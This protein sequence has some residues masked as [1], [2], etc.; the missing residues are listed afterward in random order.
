MRKNAIRLTESELITLVSR[1]VNEQT[2]VEEKEKELEEGFLGDKIGWVMDAAKNVAD[3]F[4]K[5]YIDTGKMP[6]KEIEDLAAKAEGA[7]PSEDEEEEVDVEVETIS[8]MKRIPSSNVLLNEGLIFEGKVR[9]KVMRLLNKAGILGGLGITLGGFA[10]FVSNIPGYVDST[11][12]TKVHEM[13]E[14]TFNCGFAC[15][16]LGFLAMVIGIAIAIFNAA[17]GHKRRPGSLGESRRR[18]RVIREAQMGNISWT[19]AKGEEHIFKTV[20]D[21]LRAEKKL[22]LGKFELF[23]KLGPEMTKRFGDKQ[24]FASL[25]KIIQGIK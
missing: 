25:L 3:M 4:T 15:G 10:S 6:K 16:A 5:E 12:L 11:F 24:G 9:D 13:I 21:I 7:L 18:R 8:E 19:D 14:N 22:G 23:R 2:K 1:V 20:E 17:R